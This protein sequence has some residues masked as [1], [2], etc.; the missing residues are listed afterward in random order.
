[1]ETDIIIKL[2]KNEYKK[3][4]TNWIIVILVGIIG[5]TVHLIWL[6]FTVWTIINFG[7]VFYGIVRLIKV[8]HMRNKDLKNYV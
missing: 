6:K 1:M 7:V 3:A 8:L 5:V 2:I 4:I